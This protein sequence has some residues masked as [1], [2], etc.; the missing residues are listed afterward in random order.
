MKIGSPPR[1]H[2]NYQHIEEC[3]SSDFKKEKEENM[4][5]EKSKRITYNCGIKNY[6]KE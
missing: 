1:L 2:W 5:F 3:N 4:T 6:I